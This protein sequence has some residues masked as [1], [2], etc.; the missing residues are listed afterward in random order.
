MKNFL[1]VNENIDDAE[2][3]NRCLDFTKDDID[4]NQLIKNLKDFRSKQK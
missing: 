2:R 3:Y 4:V 1:I